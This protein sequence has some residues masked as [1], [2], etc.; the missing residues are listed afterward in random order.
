MLNA[1]RRDKKQ[2]KKKKREIENKDRNEHIQNYRRDA[3]WLARTL[4]KRKVEH[5]QIDYYSNFQVHLYEYTHEECVSWTPCVL[6]I[7]RLIQEELFFL[8]LSFF[9][10]H[11]SYKLIFVSFFLYI[12]ISRDEFDGKTFD[13]RFHSITAMWKFRL[14]SLVRRSIDAFV[15]IAD[16]RNKKENSFLFEH[17]YGY[18]QLL[19]KNFVGGRNEITGAGRLVEYYVPVANR[20]RCVYRTISKQRASREFLSRK[21]RSR[22]S[23]ESAKH[24]DLVAN[25]SIIPF[26]FPCSPISIT[27]SNLE[28]LELPKVE[29]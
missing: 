23:R 9:F 3:T 10:S 16:E 15:E 21:V 1:R 12:R 18:M 14:L 17:I 7:D 11:L 2:I 5:R 27:I 26:Y 19:F 22:T 8:F 25:G 20:Q 28:T 13:V 29:I 6:G 24:R 4:V